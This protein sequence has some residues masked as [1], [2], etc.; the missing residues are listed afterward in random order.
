MWGEEAKIKKYD[1][2][3]YSEIKQR[4]KILTKEQVRFGDF[5]ALSMKTPV[6]PVPIDSMQNLLNPV[7][8]YSKESV[9]EPVPFIV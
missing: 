3:V 6:F 8:R 5:F 7:P 4:L 9:K 2:M 1:Y